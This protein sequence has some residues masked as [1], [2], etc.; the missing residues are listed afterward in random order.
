MRRGQIG[1][2]A[3]QPRA[4]K[5]VGTS[6]SR[7][8]QSQV[9]NLLILLRSRW[10]HRLWSCLSANDVSA[11]SHMPLADKFYSYNYCLHWITLLQHTKSHSSTMRTGHFLRQAPLPFKTPHAA[12][13]TL[14]IP[15]SLSNCKYIFSPPL[16]KGAIVV[17]SIGGLG[18]DVLASSNCGDKIC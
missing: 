3:A 14:P 13:A 17:R 16:E 6:Y 7:V 11:G 1:R 15:E 8:S 12:A 18:C 4:R 9:T 10:A 2:W 5:Y